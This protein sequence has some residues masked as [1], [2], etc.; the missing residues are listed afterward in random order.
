MGQIVDILVGVLLGGLITWWFARGYYK[1]AGEELKIEAG[2]I[3]KL[4]KLI[5][6]GLEEAGL[7]EFSRDKDGEP[8][9]IYINLKASGVRSKSGVR[10]T[11]TVDRKS[12]APETPA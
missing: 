2:K 10:G 5:C 11:L 7:A 8:S 12:E 9:G 6:R 4:A 3:R 1:K